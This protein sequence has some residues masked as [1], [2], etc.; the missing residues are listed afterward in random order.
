MVVV[1]AL[2]TLLATDDE[3]DDDLLFLRLSRSIIFPSR[4]FTVKVRRVGG[5]GTG[6]GVETA[7][8]SD[9]EVE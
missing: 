6:G 8:A 5:T 9:E 3:D 1:D 2:C 7:A 4:S